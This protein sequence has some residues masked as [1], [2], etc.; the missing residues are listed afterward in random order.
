[1][2]GKEEA[3]TNLR[4]AIRRRDDLEALLKAARTEVSEATVEALKSGMKP[5]DVAKTAG[6]SYETVRRAARQAGIKQ[7]REPTVT[8][9][10]GKKAGGEGDA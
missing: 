1:M 8:S 3:V 4:E 10:K 2:L 6:V 5:A 9:L 7:L